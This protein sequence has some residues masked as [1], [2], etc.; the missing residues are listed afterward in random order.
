METMNNYNGTILIV[1]LE[2]R[3]CNT[4][5]L[6]QELIEKALGGAAINMELYG[7]YADR[8]PLILGSGFLTATFA[9][10]ACCGVMTA[11]SPVT[12]SIAHV[13]FGWQ[14][15][16]ELKL[17]GF[18]FVVILGKAAGPVRLW[19]HAG[20]SDINDSTVLW[21][22][23][24][25]EA[26][27]KLRELYGDDMIQSFVIGRAGE[28]KSTLAQV[29]ENYWGSK[30]KA[31]LGAVFGAK[32][33]K[34]VAMRGLGALEVAE[35]FFQKCMELKQAISGGPSKGKAGIKDVGAAL[36]IDAAALDRI[37]SLTHRNDAGFNCPYPYYTFLKYNEAPTA[38]DMKGSKE[39][40]CLISDLTGF[41]AL[42]SAGLDAAKAMEACYRLGLEPA[43]AGNL[44]KKQGASDPAALDKLAGEGKSEGPAPWPI[45]NSNE[46]SIR[47][48]SKAFS[49]AVPP[50]AI[51]GPDGDAAWWLK[52]QAA[53]YVLGIDPFIILMAP[54]MTE[55]KLVELVKI[56]A[57]WEEFSLADLERIT[58]GL[59]EK[60]K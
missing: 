50:R 6:S 21:G 2:A 29:S 40:G 36:G 48:I 4:E 51:F 56:S 18:D 46:S 15:G 49:T 58:V 39:P 25:W 53:A 44:L 57:E 22:K 38:M 33:L 52:R 20:L 19:L 17:T 14:T 34:A 28:N 9:P 8:D 35:G 5:E 3:S 42:H 55:E 7:Q 54:E 59:I 27:V 26:V 10:A 47:G 11:K 31:G 24:V 16:V 1:D 41:A 32:N 23:A 43:A 60:S 12:G 45:Q 30:D 37:K 13:P